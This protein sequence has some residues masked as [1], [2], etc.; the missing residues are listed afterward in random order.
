MHYVKLQLL[1]QSHIKAQYSESAQTM[2]SNQIR[3]IM[4]GKSFPYSK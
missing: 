2:E 1:T 3:S 4:S